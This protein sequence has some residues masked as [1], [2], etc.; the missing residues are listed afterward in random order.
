MLGSVMDLYHMGG[1]ESVVPNKE[2][3]EQERHQCI[4]K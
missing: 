3:L 1:V 4:T 2:Y